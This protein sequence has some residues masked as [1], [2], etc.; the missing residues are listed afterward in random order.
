MTSRRSRDRL[1]LEAR[2]PIGIARE[3]V[4]RID[5]GRWLLWV[6]N[7]IVGWATFA[8][9]TSGRILPGGM[10]LESYDPKGSSAS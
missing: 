2:L 3:L 8:N 10:I 6:I 7:E 9:I 1:S 4:M 5:S